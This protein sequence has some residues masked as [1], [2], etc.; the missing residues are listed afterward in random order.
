[1]TTP[2]V[3]T[4]VN[5]AIDFCDQELRRIINQRPFNK[6]ATMNHMQFFAFMMEQK[7]KLQKPKRG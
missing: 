6:D 4:I 7:K 1:M 3:Q 5:E 2:P